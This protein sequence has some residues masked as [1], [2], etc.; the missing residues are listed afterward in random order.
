MGTDPTRKVRDVTT[1]RAGDGAPLKRL[2]RTTKQM[3]DRLLRAL[4]DRRL[5]GTFRNR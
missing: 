1:S 3:H 2:P 4:S 5:R